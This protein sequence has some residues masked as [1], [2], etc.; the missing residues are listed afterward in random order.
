MPMSWVRRIVIK[1]VVNYG[2]SENQRA[3]LDSCK[4][5]PR[6]KVRIANIAGPDFMGSLSGSRRDVTIDNFGQM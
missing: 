5:E 6:C 2:Q 3:E 4:V 1:T